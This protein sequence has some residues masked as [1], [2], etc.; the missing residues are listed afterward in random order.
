MAGAR[1]IDFDKLSKDPDYCIKVIAGMSLG[2]PELRT[3]F[4]HLSKECSPEVA[5]RMYYDTSIT[6]KLSRRTNDDFLSFKMYLLN[7]TVAIASYEEIIKELILNYHSSQ[8]DWRQG[9]LLVLT[10]QLLNNPE[11][12]KAFIEDKK[13]HSFFGDDFYIELQKKLAESDPNYAAKI[14]IA[15]IMLPLDPAFIKEEIKNIYKFNEPLSTEENDILAIAEFLANKDAVLVQLGKLERILK[16]RKDK[17]IAAGKHEEFNE[18]NPGEYKHNKI[19]SSFLYDWAKDNKFGGYAKFM[20]E[21]DQVVIAKL[22]QQML[23]FKDVA[24]RGPIHGE[25]THFLQWYCLVEA[26]TDAQFLKTAPAKLLAW[27]GEN[28]NTLWDKTFEGDTLANRSSLFN[29]LFDA[30][31]FDKFNEYLLSNECKNLFPTLHEFVY[32]RSLKEVPNVSPGITNKI[33]KF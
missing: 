23:L 8:Q 17:M 26:N 25:W 14:D 27:L 30:R 1:Q 32:S 13:Y 31:S 16:E 3:I 24:F 11:F 22:F 20:T 2:D 12:R 21:Q 33:Y 15:T 7:K 28:R 10:H 4:S 18:E 6:I 9:A 5:K 19:L 29:P